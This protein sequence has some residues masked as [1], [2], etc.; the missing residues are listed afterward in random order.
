MPAALTNVREAYQAGRRARIA[1][2]SIVSNNYLNPLMIL[3]FER[4]WR[5]AEK[6]K[7]VKK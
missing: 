1:G 4:G 7:E 6:R 5:S 2:R 3:A